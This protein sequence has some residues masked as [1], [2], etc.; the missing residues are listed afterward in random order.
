MTNQ[1]LYTKEELKRFTDFVTIVRRA[2]VFATEA[3]KGVYRKGK[4]ENGE[5]LEY[6]THPIAVAKILHKAKSSHRIA[7]LISVCMLHDTVEDV[8]WV[9][10]DVI[11]KI[12]GN[13]V[14]SLVE[15]LTS[16]P[17]GIEAL[18]KETYLKNKMLNMSTW[19]LGIK[20]AD[21][22]HN[23]SDVQRKIDGGKPSDLRW[24]IKYCTQTHNIVK[25]LEEGRTL[26]NTHKRLIEEIKGLIEPGL[27]VEIGFLGI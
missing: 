15:E 9:T 6:I 1:E 22:I 10:I 20:L 19:G 27:Q 25:A 16:D 26:T 11:K 8:E 3:H 12:F 14:A 18:G 4:D 17:K 21:R 7:E 2:R 13:L 24:V 23:L 5:R